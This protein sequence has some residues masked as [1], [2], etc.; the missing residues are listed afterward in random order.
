MQLARIVSISRILAE[1]GLGYLTGETTDSPPETEVAVRLRRTLERLGPTFVKFGQMLATRVDLFGEAVLTE[2]SRLHASVSPFDGAEAL[3]IVE[4]ELGRPLGEV[5]RSLSPE[6]VAAASIAQVHRGML[7]DGSDVAVKVQRPGIEDTLLSDLTTLVELSTYLDRLVPPYRK[8]M[9][10]QVAEE[11]ALRA[12]TELDFRA[13]ARAMDR[14]AD[15]LTNLPEFRVPVVH[16]A[17]CTGKLVVMEW[18]DGPKL[19]DAPDAAT[20]AAF[21]FEPEEFC[22]SMLRLQL[23]MCY[24]H[25]FVHGD[26]HPGNLILEPTGRIGLID[27]GLHAQVPRLVRDKM[28]EVVFNQASGRIDD[29]VTAYVQ[30]LK[31]DGSV[32]VPAL[33]RDLKAVLAE[34]GEGGAIR[35]HRI[36]EQLVRGM[37]V[38]ARY[39]VRAQSELFVVMRNLTLVEGIVLRYCPTLDVAAEVRTITGG[40]LRR[41]VFGPSM[42]AE[43]DQLLPQLAL[44]LSQRPRLAERLMKLERSF[45]EAKSLGD[46]LRQEQILQTPERAR[47]PIGWVAAVGVVGIVVGWVLA[48]LVAG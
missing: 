13:E 44:T 11:Y 45:V 29:A 12:R 27:F 10:H 19:V 22:R 41:R 14:F 31:P 21:G 15:V 25:G 37:R 2:L 7:L 23:S 47:W 34:G 3:R 20:L 39:Q 40:I 5:F 6:P 26:T 42:R 33:E 32:D 46:F 8:A 16:T 38:G 1:E 48:V 18:I 43:F 36:T 4:A 30:L 17:W 35:D 24:E 28:L 9:V